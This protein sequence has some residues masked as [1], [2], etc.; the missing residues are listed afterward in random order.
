MAKKSRANAT[1]ANSSTGKAPAKSASGQGQGSA[2]NASGQGQAKQE[3]RQEYLDRRKRR[4]E[5][6]QQKKDDRL[7]TYEKNKR[8]ALLTK[9]GFGILAALLVIWAGYWG[10]GQW[11]DREVRADVKTYFSAADFA[12]VHE[13]GDILYEEIPPVGGPHNAVWQNC[14]YYSVPLNNP[15]AVHALEH[16]AVWITYNPD[17]PADQVQQLKDLTK[18]TYVLVSPYP[19]ISNPVTASVWGKQMVL[20][21]FD[22]DKLKSFISQY[23]QNPD[24]TPERGALCSLGTSAVMTSGSPQT[25]PYVQADP[26]GKPIGGLTTEQATATAQALAGGTPDAAGSPTVAPTEI[27]STVAGPAMPGTPG[28]S[29]AASP[30]ASPGASPAASPAASPEASPAA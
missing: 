4:P 15:N 16:G 28:A 1:P 17:L 21:S 10:W 19:G 24:N 13:N 3:T 23:R 8:N 25:V 27:P 22:I 20:E 18:Q 6:V 5:A 30:L 2:Q 9:I 7:K 14:G 29:P 26:N 12:G 11:Q